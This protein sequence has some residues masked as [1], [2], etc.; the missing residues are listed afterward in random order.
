MLEKINHTASYI[1]QQ[2]N[3]QPDFGIVL[4]SGLGGLVNEITIQRALDYSSIPNFPVSTVKGHSGKLIFGTLGG[5]NVMALQGRFHYYEGYS[6]QEVTFPIRVMK[7]LGV[8]RLILSNAAGGMN[9]AYQIGD[10]VIIHDHI[11][12]MPSN[13]LIGKNYDELGPRFPDMSEPYDKEMISL[14]KKIADKKG[15]RSHIGVYAGVPGPCF[16]TPAEYKYIRTIGADLVGMSTVP[17]VIAARHGNTSCFAISIVTDLGGFDE[18]E[19]VSHEAVLKVATA[20]EGKMTA[21]IRELI[22]EIG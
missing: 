15:Y 14:A 2:I 9:P 8:K 21:I 13:P 5:K 22:A 12:L 18:A 19:K 11:N 6:M 1:R 3:F 10:V 17:E 7:A 16:E 20:A 4:G